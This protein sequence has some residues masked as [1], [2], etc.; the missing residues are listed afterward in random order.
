MRGLLRITAV[1]ASSVA[2]LL[3]VMSGAGC[4][5]QKVGSAKTAA[6]TM[7]GDHDHSAHEHGSA[8]HEPAEHD[9]GAHAAQ[10]G[11]DAAGH[12]HSAHDHGAAG[13]K[14]ATGAAEQIAQKLCPV[15]DDEIDSEVFTMHNGRKVY[16]CCEDCIPKFKK[17]PAKYLAKLDSG[18]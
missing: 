11:H 5:N 15:M 3:F 8:G 1:G 9:H 14:P 13:H 2:M 16:F 6:K 7:S 4:N 17:D 12:D 10:S 18:T